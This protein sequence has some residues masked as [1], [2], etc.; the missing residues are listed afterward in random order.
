MAE[1]VIVSRT[2]MKNGVCCGGVS[3]STG[4]Y[5]RIHDSRG[6]N[7]SG[8]APYQIGEVYDMGYRKAW[9]VRPRPH[10]EDCQVF[11]AHYLRKMSLRQLES[12]I[13]DICD[14]CEGDL[15]DVFDGCLQLENYAPYIDRGDIPR[16]SVCFWRPKRPLRKFQMMGKTRY[17]YNGNNI[18]F[19][20][21]QPPL[22]YIPAGTLVRLSLANWWAKDSFSEKKCYLQISGWYNS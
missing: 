1:V 16:H 3:L 20:G 9:N 14:V 8:D 19:V 18:S 5:I 12:T 4:Q 7:L 21:F 13:D 11:S 17:S 6:R 15:D 10:V 22:S 2:K